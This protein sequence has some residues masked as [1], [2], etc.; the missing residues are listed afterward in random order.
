MITYTFKK[1]TI[2]NL[3]DFI[4][5]YKNAF[6]KIITNEFLINK[7]NPKIFGENCIGYIAYDQNKT[8]SAFYGV[9]PCQIEYH[10]KLL[11]LFFILL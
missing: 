4:P 11:V 3:S 5:I 10:G 6:R 9:Y 7:I 1:L 2:E 8:P